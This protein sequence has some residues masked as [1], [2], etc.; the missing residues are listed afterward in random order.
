[1]GH[2][3]EPETSVNP[4]TDD[5]L[6]PREEINPMSHTRAAAYSGRCSKRV[7]WIFAVIKCGTDLN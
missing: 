7:Q 2:T 4:P 1:M 3:A 5:G 6:T